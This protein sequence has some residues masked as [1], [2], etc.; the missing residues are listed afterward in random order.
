MRID[1]SFFSSYL[2]ET[3]P[4]AKCSLHFSSPFE[5][6]VAVML[7]AQTTDAS[8]NKVTPALFAKFPTPFE[9]S[10]ASQKEVEACI[11]SLGLFH[12]KAKNLIALSKVLV[13]Q[14]KGDVPSSFD[15]LVSLPG[16]GVKTANVVSAECF[17]RPSIPVD[18]HV[19]RVSKRVGYAKKDDEPVVVEKKLEKIF[20]KESWIPLHH[21]IIA[22][23]REICHAQK[24]ECDRCGFHSVCPYKAKA[25][26][27]AGK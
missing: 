25:L 3:F 12:N 27:K 15:D 4:D 23:G 10:K 2:E 9:L 11:Q 13:E 24:P 14:F 18:T 22:F 5:A 16:V 20:P 7:S 6:L 8:V 21:R 19:G 1:P 26:T 17:A